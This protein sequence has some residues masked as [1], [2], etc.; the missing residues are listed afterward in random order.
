TQELR[1]TA[2]RVLEQAYEQDGEVEPEL[3]LLLAMASDD[4]AEK[5]GDKTNALAT[6]AGESSSLRRLLRP[7]EGRFDRLALSRNGAWGALSTSTGAVQVVSTKSGDVV[8]RQKGSRVE[9]TARGV[10]V[11]GLAV[12]PLGQRVAFATSDLRL[13]VVEQKKGSWS[14]TKRMALP[15]PSHPGL[16]NTERNKVDHLEFTSDHRSLVLYVDTIGMLVYDVRHLDA[17]PRRCPERGTAQTMQAG[18]NAVLLTK[19]REVVRVDL[20]TCARSVVLTVPK[21]ME[22]HGAVAD[23]GVVAAATRGAQLLVLS[24][25]SPETLIADRGPYGRVS[26]TSADDG[27]HLSATRLTGRIGGTYG[28]NV[29]RRTQ[30]Y[31]YP[32]AGPSLMGND[33]VLRHRGGVAELHD[34]DHSAATRAWNR[35]YAGMGSLAW[36]GEDLVLRSGPALYVLPDAK[37][38]TSETMTDP[39]YYHRLPL[40]GGATSKELATSRTGPWAAA[41]YSRKGERSRDLAVWNLES[42]RTTPVPLPKKTGLR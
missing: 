33:I 32:G 22:L 30:E 2:A 10:F 14:V 1:D 38:L 9:P 42:R 37:D 16:L 8:W 3:R 28:W 24:P 18:E 41:L 25:K 36:A 27:A 7:E 4:I 29:A 20:K 17:P 26:I 21:D 12:S 11:H 23:D 15:I 39:A 6:M 19:D 13:T 40:P 31:G 34:G 5:A 35:F